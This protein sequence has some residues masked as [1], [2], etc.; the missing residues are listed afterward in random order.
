MSDKITVTLS[1]ANMGPDATERDFDAWHA[2]VCEH[3]D[4]GS[5]V[6]VHEVEQADF[7]NGPP[8]DVVSGAIGDQRERVLE[9][10][11]VTG[12]E[13][14]CATPEAWPCVAGAAENE[15][16]CAAAGSES[17][18]IEGVVMH[19]CPAHAAEVDADPGA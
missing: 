8:N 5:G 1:V 7:A 10:L 2:Y 14:F 19:L 11:A 17:R 3:I 15:P 4:E 13:A 16:A 18:T 6:Y 12:W 9:W